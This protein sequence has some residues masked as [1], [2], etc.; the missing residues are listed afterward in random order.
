MTPIDCLR[1]RFEAHRRSDYAAIYATYHPDA[2]FLQQFPDLD[3]Y[4]DFARENLSSIQMMSWQCIMERRL[5]PQQSECIQILEFD[6]C[7]VH[8]RMAE[9]ALLV[10]TAQGWL[11]HSAQ[12]LDPDALSVPLALVDFSHF[13]DAVDK[14]RF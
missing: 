13:D 6:Q 8:C 9:L 5:D 14:V 2:P 10:L 7:G 3:Y 11:F 12:K 1:Q 4:A